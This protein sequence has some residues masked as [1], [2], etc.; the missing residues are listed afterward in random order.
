MMMIVSLGSSAARYSEIYFGRQSQT[1]LAACASH[2]RYGVESGWNRLLRKSRL[3]TRLGP[4]FFC[5][6]FGRKYQFENSLFGL[7][8]VAS[9][10]L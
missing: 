10:L 5:Y 1:A 3:A 7:H 4:K 8:V 2:A 9:C 6:S